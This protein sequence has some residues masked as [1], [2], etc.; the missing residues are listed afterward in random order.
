MHIGDA[1]QKSCGD[2]ALMTKGGLGGEWGAWERVVKGGAG[3]GS[4]GGECNLCKGKGVKEGR[5][6]LE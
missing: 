5:H 2:V 1:S 6:D 3:N 4:Q